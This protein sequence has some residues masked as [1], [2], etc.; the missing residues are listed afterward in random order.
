M[1]TLDELLEDPAYRKYFAKVPKLKNKNR[2]EPPWMLYL[3]HKETKRWHGKRFNTYA[4]AYKEYKRLNGLGKVMNGAICCPGQG[5]KPPSRIVKVK[6]QYR[7]DSK[8]I[9]W[10]VTKAVPWKPK[11]P[12]EEEAHQWCPYCRRPTT[13][14]YYAQHHALNHLT[15]QGISINPAVPRCSICGASTNVG[16]QHR[17]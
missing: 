10:Q 16:Q 3:Q 8:G 4:E 5:F 17:K 7:T 15:P 6:N 14:G 12:A 13:F 2:I 1:I 9:R 11:L